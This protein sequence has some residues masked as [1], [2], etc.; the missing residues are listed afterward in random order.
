[1]F[2]ILSVV[3][4]NFFLNIYCI[5]ALDKASEICSAIEDQKQY[6]K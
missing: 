1:M 4:K 3:M 5:S 6:N 2:D